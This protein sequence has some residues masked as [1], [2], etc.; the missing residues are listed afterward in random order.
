MILCLVWICPRIAFIT[1]LAAEEGYEE[2][3]H[4]GTKENNVPRRKKNICLELWY[5]GEI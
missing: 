1:Y 3:H 2:T 5:C 4:L